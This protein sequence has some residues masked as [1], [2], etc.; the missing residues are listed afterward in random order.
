MAT[1]DIVLENIIYQL[2]LRVDQTMDDWSDTACLLPSNTH[3]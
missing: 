1:N 2:D 3:T